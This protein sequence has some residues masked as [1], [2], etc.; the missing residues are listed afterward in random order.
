MRLTQ[1]HYTMLYFRP[2]HT[3]IE[4]PQ[5]IAGWQSPAVLRLGMAT[6]RNWRKSESQLVKENM[7]RDATSNK[8]NFK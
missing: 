5:K 2:A 8:K 7:D 6:L 1:N 4:S 3:I